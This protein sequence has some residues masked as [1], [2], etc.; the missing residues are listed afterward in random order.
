[1]LFTLFFLRLTQ[2]HLLL[3]ETSPE[4]SRCSWHRFL[5]AGGFRAEVAGGA[6]KIFPLETLPSPVIAE[7]MKDEFDET[8]KVS[9]EN[10]S[11]TDFALELRS[12]LCGFV[13]SSVTGAW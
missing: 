2:W 5:N 4:C 10:S 9:F 8:L 6:R 13:K 1:M 11:S 3:P 7:D 12:A